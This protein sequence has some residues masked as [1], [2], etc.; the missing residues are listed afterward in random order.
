MADVSWDPLEGLDAASV[1]RRCL[2]T[3]GA[4]YLGR[5]LAS[6]LAA[7]GCEVRCLDVVASKGLPAEVE[8]RVADV[9]DVR[10][11]RAAV[12]GVD[13]VFH[14]AALIDWGAGGGEDRVTAVNLDGARVV[15]DACLD[16][17]VRA[18]VHTSTMDVVWEGRSVRDADEIH[19]YDTRTFE[20]RAVLAGKKPSG[21]F[22]TARAHRTGL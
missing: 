17:G 14:C 7:L 8:V 11:V 15:L 2:V 16:A 13:V 1:G 6:R 12:E 18:L 20:K 9:R 21:I 5:H 22:F 3:G 4:G 10:A 19:V